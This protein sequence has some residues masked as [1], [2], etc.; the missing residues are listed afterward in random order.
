MINFNIKYLYYILIFLGFLLFCKFLF[1][2]N[3]IGT[4]SPRCTS[5]QLTKTKP[6]DTIPRTCSSD[7]DCAYNIS[8]TMAGCT[9]NTEY[10]C[11][12]P[13]N[14][15][16]GYTCKKVTN[17]TTLPDIYNPN[18][19]ISPP[20]VSTKTQFMNGPT[21]NCPISKLQ[22]DRGNTNVGCLN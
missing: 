20:P 16:D 22:I 10:K 2:E 17:Y 6:S 18:M 14:S 21:I 4:L 13:I 19:I 5:A 8:G 9:T 3:F 11:M 7:Y 15:N 12:T 1:F